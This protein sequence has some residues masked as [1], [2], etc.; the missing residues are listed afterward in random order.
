MGRQENILWVYSLPRFGV[1]D[2]SCTCLQ[3]HTYIF[4][5]VVSIHC[6][7]KRPTTAINRI[8]TSHALVLLSWMSL[9]RLELMIFLTFLIGPQFILFP[10]SMERY[11]VSYRGLRSSY[12]S[13]CNF[14]DV[15]C[16]YFAKTPM[17]KFQVGQV[18]QMV[19]LSSLTSRSSCLNL[20]SLDGT[21][22]VRHVWPK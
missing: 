7:T 4:L 19:T 21:A 17:A 14:S 15:S 18:R 12:D 11:C 5:S 10:N 8:D 16:P 1:F 20:P 3:R 2:G 6:R 13:F 9:R 22:C